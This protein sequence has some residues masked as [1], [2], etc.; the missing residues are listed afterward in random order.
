MGRRISVIGTSGNGK[1]TVAREL[2]QRLRVPY[3]ELDGLFHGPG[4]EETA[5]E[6]FRRRVASATEADG[7]VV[8]G[9]YHTKL[10]DLVLGRA[11]T[12]VWLDQPLPLLLWRIARRTI[13]RIRR[14]EELWNGNRETWR[15]GF[16]GWNSMFVWT[17]R[18]YFRR[19]R[20]FPDQLSRHPHVVRL[21][22]P[23]DVTRWLKSV[24]RE[25]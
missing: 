19:R 15:G 11:D 16:F 5:V 3:V 14:G 6:D 1:T 20:L 9:N 21:R 10:G 17:I 12:V 8:D 24:S 4:W 13:R 23:R 2:A 22:S 18:S 7:W 25:D